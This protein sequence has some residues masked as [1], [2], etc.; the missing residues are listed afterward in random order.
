MH[1]FFSHP[2]FRVI[3]N[4]S[5]EGRVSTQHSVSMKVRRQ[6]QGSVLVF[7]FE[8]RF[9]CCL[10]FC[11][12]DYLALKIL[13]ILLSPYFPS[14][15]RCVRI[16]DVCYCTHIYLGILIPIFI[17]AW[18]MFLYGP[19]FFISCVPSFLFRLYILFLI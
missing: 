3:R 6:S 1:D 2:S 19:P 11:I 10:L 12:T 9:L 18:L 15:H 13:G 8:T 17:Y 16:T 5:G 7:C 14:S 4:N